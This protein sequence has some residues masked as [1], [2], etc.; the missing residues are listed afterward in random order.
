MGLIFPFAHKLVGLTDRALNY[1]WRERGIISGLPMISHGAA[2]Q[3]YRDGVLARA[4]SL[5]VRLAGCTGPHLSFME[6]SQ[7]LL[8]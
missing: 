8:R 2:H 6:M 3:G 7:Q 5:A 1:T 4:F